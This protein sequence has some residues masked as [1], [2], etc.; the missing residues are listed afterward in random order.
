MVFMEAEEPFKQRFFNTPEGFPFCQSFTTGWSPLSPS[1]N[2]CDYRKKC[3]ETTAKK[4]PEL[5]RHRKETINGK[6][7]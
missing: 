5:V 3:E 1:C 4:Y 6:E 2:V 7:K